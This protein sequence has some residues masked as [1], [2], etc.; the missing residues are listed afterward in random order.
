MLNKD[1]LKE[2]ARLRFE[3]A[4]CDKIDYILGDCWNQNVKGRLQEVNEI[5]EAGSV[6]GITTAQSFSKAQID[7]LTRELCAFKNLGMRVEGR[8][9]LISVIVAQGVTA[10]LGDLT[11]G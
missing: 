10:E 8:E 5:I 11:I 2:T 9:H 7:E 4:L 1:V 3:A 6:F